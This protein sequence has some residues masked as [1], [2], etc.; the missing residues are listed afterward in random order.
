[1]GNILAVEPSQNLSP[2]L[3]NLVHGVHAYRIG[4]PSGTQTWQNIM[5][6]RSFT[7]DFPLIPPIS[8]GFSIADVDPNNFAEQPQTGTMGFQKEGHPMRQ[9]RQ[10]AHFVETS[11][12]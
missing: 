6:H 2:H 1:L 12:F 9:L 10:D 7:V 4:V 8:T 3:A 11:A 5:E